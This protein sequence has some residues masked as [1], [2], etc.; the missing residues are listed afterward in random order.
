MVLT[1]RSFRGNFA[2]VIASVL[3]EV[4]FP[5]F[6]T[7]ELLNSNLKLSLI[8]K[9]ESFCIEIEFGF[10]K[11]RKTL[12]EGLKLGIEH[13]K[14]CGCKNLYIDGSFVTKKEIPSDFDACWD[15]DGVDLAK[16]ISSYPTIVN[17]DEGRKYQKLLYGGEFFLMNTKASPYDTF[18]N[19]FQKDRDGNKKGIVN[20]KLN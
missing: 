14:D 11:I 16:L 15:E 20:I 4:M 12:I 18:I 2:I 13:L 3:Q 8:F 17:F 5:F 7:P 10:N 6:I 19:F 9:I 1:I